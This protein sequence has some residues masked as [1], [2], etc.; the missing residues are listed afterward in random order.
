VSIPFPHPRK[1]VLSVVKIPRPRFP[2][3]PIFLPPCFCL[4]LIPTR[5]LSLPGS[6][7]V[8]PPPSEAPRRRRVCGVNASSPS[9]K[10]RVIR[11]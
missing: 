3:A 8:A 2:A 10:I 6:T 11:G 1:S 4:I 9:V 5:P 7:S